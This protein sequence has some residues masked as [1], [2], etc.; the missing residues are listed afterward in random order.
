MANRA[1]ITH[2]YTDQIGAQSLNPVELVSLLVEVSAYCV[3]FHNADLAPSPR[4]RTG[5]K[6]MIERLSL[7]RL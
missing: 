5:S 4:L 2:E 6:I 7:L 1:G 3:N